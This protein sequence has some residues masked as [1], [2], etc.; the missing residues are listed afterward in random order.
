MWYE[1]GQKNIQA[2]NNFV[3]FG[4][5]FISAF[6]LNILPTGLANSVNRDQTVPEGAF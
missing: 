5:F 4:I 3:C 6:N 2:E 1:S